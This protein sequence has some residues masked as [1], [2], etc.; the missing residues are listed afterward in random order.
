MYGENSLAR[1]IVRAAVGCLVA[2]MGI[3]IATPFFLVMAAP[4]TGGL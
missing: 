2:A 4:F 1:K 3:A